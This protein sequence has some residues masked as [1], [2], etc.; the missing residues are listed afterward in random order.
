[1]TDDVRALA[2][3]LAISS[4][5]AAGVARSSGRRR[6]RIPN[7][8]ETMAGSSSAVGGRRGFNSL[9]GKPGF[10]NQIWPLWRAEIWQ[11]CK[12]AMPVGGQGAL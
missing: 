7:A 11:A 4:A 1:M 5:I 3:A 2:C 10:L 8:A 9:I 12:N 6:G